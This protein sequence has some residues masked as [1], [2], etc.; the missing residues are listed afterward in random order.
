MVAVS[1]RTS[2]INSKNQPSATDVVV[3]VGQP[4]SFPKQANEILVFV[5]LV[6][7]LDRQY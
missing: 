6:C 3:V 5:S 4:A 2:T 1:W 7:W